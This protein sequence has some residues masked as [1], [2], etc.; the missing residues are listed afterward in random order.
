[1]M[2]LFHGM[3]AVPPGKQFI[4]PDP[5][6][7]EE[8]AVILQGQVGFANSGCFVHGWDVEFILQDDGFAVWDNMR[9]RGLDGYVRLIKK[10]GQLIWEQMIQTPTEPTPP[11]PDE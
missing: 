3:H 4:P 2:F 9:F 8:G 1:M 11:K 6:K 10:D 5:D 7:V